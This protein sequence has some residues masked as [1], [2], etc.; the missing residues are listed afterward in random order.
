[1]MRTV[2]PVIAL[3]GM[4]AASAMADLE[5]SVYDPAPATLT[6][7]GEHTVGVYGTDGTGE[8]VIHTDFKLS[9][10]QSDT[11]HLTFAFHWNFA[12]SVGIV[13]MWH[14]F[15]YDNS[16][17]SV[18]SMAPAGPFAGGASNFPG[19]TTWQGTALNPSGGV[20]TVGDVLGTGVPLWNDPTGGAPLVGVSDI[21]PFM[22]VDLH[23]KNVEPDSLMDAIVGSAALLFT[24]AGATGVWWTS[25]ALGN[26]S[27]YGAGIVPE[28][29]S[30]SLLGLG[31]VLLG[32]GLWRRR[33]C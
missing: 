21:V 16:E 8:P 14:S 18:L 17:V 2:I 4:A 9:A 3:L 5:P 28:P 22:Q 23:V 33:R 26:A 1:M 11:I 12:T 15:T 6:P 32:S 31:L 30:L 25:G 13:E 10:T 19:A 24:V 20:L 27:S 29:A 7:A